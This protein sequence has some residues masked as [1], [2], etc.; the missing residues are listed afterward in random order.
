VKCTHKPLIIKNKPF[1]KKKLNTNLLGQTQ[2][3]KNVKNKP[4]I[5]T[6]QSEGDES[7]NLGVFH[8]S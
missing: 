7:C 6:S 1:A 8:N 5:T 2:N 3:L 4:E